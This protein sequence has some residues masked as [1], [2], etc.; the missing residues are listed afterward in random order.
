MPGPNSAAPVALFADRGCR[1]R[2]PVA[3]VEVRSWPLT[4]AGPWQGAAAAGSR[5][6]AARI[7]QPMILRVVMGPMWERHGPGVVVRGK[8]RGTWRWCPGPGADL[9]ADPA[10]PDLL[11]VQDPEVARRV[12]SAWSTSAGSTA[13]RSRR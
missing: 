13:S 1:C 7:R 11:D 4:C 9:M 2:V 5:S 6:P 8:R 10:Q 3:F 12:L